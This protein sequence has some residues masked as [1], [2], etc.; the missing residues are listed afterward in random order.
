MQLARMP[1]ATCMDHSHTVC[2]LPKIP[3]KDGMEAESNSRAVKRTVVMRA[4]SD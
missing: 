1:I 2:M 3:E 4:L